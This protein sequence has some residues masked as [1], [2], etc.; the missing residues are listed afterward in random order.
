M[1]TTLDEVRHGLETGDFVTFTEVQGMDCLNGCEPV[2][3][4]VTGMLGRLPQSAATSATYPLDHIHVRHART[5]LMEA[6]VL[7]SQKQALLPVTNKIDM[8]MLTPG[9]PS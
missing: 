2:R 4:N 6:N 9:L 5:H 8:I 7:A 1:V 3:V